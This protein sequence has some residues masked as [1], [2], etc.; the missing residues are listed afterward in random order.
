MSA[1]MQ[2]VT[3]RVVRGFAWLLVHACYRVRRRRTGLIPAEGAALLVANHVS[4]LDAVLV[5]L[6]SPRPVRFVMYYRIFQAPLLSWFFRALGAIPI[7][8]AKEDPAIHEAAFAR[9]ATALQAGELVCIFPEGQLTKDG[10]MT[11]FRPGVL[12]ILRETPVPVVPVAVRGAWGSIFTYCRDLRA[13]TWPRRLWRRLEVVVG[14]ALPPTATLEEMQAR[15]LG[16][17]GAKL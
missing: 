6:A 3:G 16:L 8:G 15:V 9:I 10:Q 12:R 5:A 11:P 2:E 17:R 1:W 7:A 14:H 13:R 4:F